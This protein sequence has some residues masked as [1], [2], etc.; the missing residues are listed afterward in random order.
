MTDGRR[1]VVIGTGPAGL[2]A[3]LAAAR[4]GARVTLVDNGAR[5]GGQYHRHAPPADEP[6]PGH[7]PVRPHHAPPAG[8]AAPGR[9]PEGQRLARAV[10][11]HPA[12]DHRPHTTVWSIEP[13]RDAGGGAPASHLVH[14]LTG[15]ADGFRTPGTLAADAL[16]LCPGAFD[17]S[18]PFPGWDLPGVVTA[19]AAQALAKGQRLAVGQRVIVAGTGPFLLPVAAALLGAGARVL[20]VWEAGSPAGWLRSPLAALRDGRGKLP[21]LAAYAGTL[22]RHR[23]PYRTRRAVVAAHGEGRLRAVT[24]ARLAPDWTVR[25]GSERRVEGVDALCVGYGFTPQ[26]EL[27]L[28]TGCALEDGPDGTPRVALRAGQRTS[29]PRVYA[30]GELTGVGGAELAAHEGELAGLMAAAALGH[31]AGDP[32]RVA[33]LRRR[34]RS[35]RRFAAAL[36]LAHPVRP[37]WHTWLR[38]D[39]LVCRCEEVTYDALRAAVTERHVDGP[40]ALKLACRAGLGACQGRTCGRAVTELAAGLT[41][42]ASV[43]GAPAPGAPAPGAP[44]PRGRRPLG[45]ADRYAID[46]RPI[47][48]PIRLGD[49]AGPPALTNSPTPSNSPAPADLPIPIDLTPPPLTSPPPDEL[50]PPQHRDPQPPDA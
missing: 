15:P 31:R 40:R 2:H 11:A 43:P 35:G 13:A 8:G 16:V 36:A 17:R 21:E 12:I 50:A 1:I 32:A 19:G 9:A 10:A 38:G 20:G 39:T 14:V 47:A 29:V 41:P 45:Y 6:S 7:A 27:A 3:A 26:L 46:T 33:W 28:A 48:Q 42:D 30:A 37:G 4:A 22:A 5:V 25:P 34:V 18:L 23:V 24:T 44:A 49:L